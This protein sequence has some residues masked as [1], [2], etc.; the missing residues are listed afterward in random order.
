M[1][2][3]RLRLTRRSFLKA[4][5]A[6]GAGAYLALHQPQNVLLQTIPGID[7]PLAFYPERDW[8]KVYR[9]LYGNRIA[10]SWNPRGCLKGYTLIHR[11]Y[12][13]YRVQH[14]VVRKGWKTWADK[15]FPVD[16]DGRPAQDLFRRG[17]GA[18][19][20]KIRP[21]MSLHGALRLQSLKRFANMLALYDGK[22]GARS[23]TNYDWHGDLPPGHPMVTGVQTFDDDHNNFRYSRL[24]IMQGVN[25]VENKMSDAHWWT[26]TIERGGK[27]VVIAPEYSAASQKADYWIPVRPGTDPALQ[28]GVTNILIQEKL[29]D[30]PFVKKFTDFPLLVRLDTLKLLKAKDI[31]AN[32][33]NA[34][35]TGYSVT[36]QKIEPEL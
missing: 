36:V 17:R 4:G 30:E 12:G 27:I 22:L 25:F 2:T 34:E 6:I 13:P 26:E 16:T 28:L 31:I 7:N 18:Q 35:L 24:F 21:G 9:D 33:Q 29:Y 10:A 3:D 11:T 32:Y 8:E 1:T 14:P 15:G 19:V 23:W 5:G 20:I